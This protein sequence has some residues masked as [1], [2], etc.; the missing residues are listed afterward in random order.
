MG[1][2]AELR[3]AYALRWRR[4]RLL[5]RAL[6]KRGRLR[7]VANRT[8]VIVARDVLAFATVRNEM[9]RLPHFLRHHRTLGVDHFLI[10]END[11]TDGTREYLAEQT[12]V[13]LWTTRDSY[14]AARFGVDWMTVLL[15]RHGHGHWCLTVDADE[16]FLY[17]HHEYRDLHALTDWLDMTG[18]SSIGALMLDV[19][20]EGRL[21]SAGTADD[22]TRILTYFD[23]GNYVMVRQ[24]RL[25]NLWIQGGP[26]ARVFFASEPR[27][28]PTMSKVPLVRWHWRYVY[29]TSTHSLLP[30][31]LNRVYGEHGAEAPTGVLLHTKFLPEIV[32][33]SAEERARRQHFE[34]SDLY[35]AYYDA[36]NDDPVL[37]C[38]AS[39]RLE[40]WRQLEDLGLMSRGGWE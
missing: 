9:G 13:S 19:Y 31:R 2:A 29:A 22:P 18:R 12:D 1:H 16:L 34:N 38:P 11:S 37:W 30:R 33:K 28:A 20:P 6:R 8:G 24:E 10:V 40:G 14:K 35:T 27:R 4:R 26:R 39:T 32:G 25:R 23:A 36:L 17:A 15:A 7:S 3:T 21:G 5:A